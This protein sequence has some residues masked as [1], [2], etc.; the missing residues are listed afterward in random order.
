MLI[1]DEGRNYAAAEYEKWLTETGFRQ[2]RRWR[3]T[4]TVAGHPIVYRAGAG[5]TV[6]LGGI[7]VCFKVPGAVTGGAFSIVEHPAR[8]GTLVPARSRRR[9][10]A[11]VRAPGHVRGSGGRCCS[12]GWPR[13]LRGQAAR[14][15]AHVLEC[16]AS[17]GPAHRDH[18]PGGFERYFTEM[19][20]LLQRHGPDFGRISDLAAG[21]HLSFRMERVDDLVARYGV[22]SSAKAALNRDQAQQGHGKDGRLPC[23][24]RTWTG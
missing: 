1:D 24:A 8:P 2:P 11:V 19:A 18:R 22:T 3:S 13:E 10:R 7:G 16:R 5:A 23:S 15:A 21:Y 14:R 4:M 12:R 20:G 17:A 6:A 9:G